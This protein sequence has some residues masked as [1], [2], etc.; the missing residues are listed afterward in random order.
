MNKGKREVI[1][2]SE[3]P[4]AEKWISEVVKH[5][6]VLVRGPNVA[7]NRHPKEKDYN[8]QVN[9]EM[10]MHPGHSDNA[11]HFVNQKSLDDLKEKV[12]NP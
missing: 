7:V 2:Y 3:G 11:V 6:V 1:G 9:E 5:S 4:E 12:G 10:R 8:C